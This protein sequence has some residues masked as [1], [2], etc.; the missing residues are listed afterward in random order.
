MFGCSEQRGLNCHHSWLLERATIL[1]FY[2]GDIA[3][4]LSGRQDSADG[5]KALAL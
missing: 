3:Q 5:E 4:Y 2:L 1:G